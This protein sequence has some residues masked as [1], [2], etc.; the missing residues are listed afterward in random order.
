MTDQKP[1][2]ED[3]AKEKI[4]IAMY[5]IAAII[6]SEEIGKKTDVLV[7]AFKESI[8]WLWKNRPEYP[9]TAKAEID[10]CYKCGGKISFGESATYDGDKIRHIMG[11]CK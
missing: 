5:S 6:H 4:G 3:E 8:C 2:N 10:Y 9:E 1:L 7:E 11:M